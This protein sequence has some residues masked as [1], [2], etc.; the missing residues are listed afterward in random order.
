MII[1]S[2]CLVGKKCSYDGENRFSAAV[3]SVC[4]KF[5]Y[6]DLCPEL[7][8][9]FG[10]PREKHEVSF[11]GG[12][13]VLNGAGKVVSESGEE[14]TD[15]FLRG[16]NEALALCLRSGAT[17]AFLKAKSP[18]CGKGMIYDGSFCGRLVAGNGVTAELLML[19]GMKVFTENEV[20]EAR[21]EIEKY[22]KSDCENE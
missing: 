9:G 10:S 20:D 8:G 2:S 21:L 18:S 3:F 1:A 14:R 22:Q 15:K 16:A 7:L 12:T 6:I 17:I 4:K 11:G 5:G 13:A 19:N